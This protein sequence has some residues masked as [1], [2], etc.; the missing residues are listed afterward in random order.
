MILIKNR[1]VRKAVGIL[2]M[3]GSAVIAFL[4]LLIFDA[5]QKYALCA[6][7]LSLLSLSLFFTGYDRKNIGSRRA[8]ICAIMIALSVAGR[9]IPL[10]KPISALTI[11]CAMY[12][13]KESGFMCGSLSALISDFYF[14]LGPWTP[15]QM[16][17]WGMIG[18]IG[19]I[20]SVTL[21]KSKIALIL[22]GSI[23]GVLFSLI[24]DIWSVLW[25]NGS[26]EFSLYKNAIVSALPFTVLYCVSNI[27]FLL[28]FADPISKKLERIKIKY[29]I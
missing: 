25:Y 2:S 12:L 7:G 8:V 9:F 11:L 13:G 26:L 28:I 22:Y 15:F 24:M 18:F 23:C 19:G 5:G 3:I 20:L 17:A 29:G 6:L 21:K 10:F 4:P 16:F 27:V 14:G 1:S